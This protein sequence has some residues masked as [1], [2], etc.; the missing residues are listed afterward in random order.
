MFSP[1][2]RAQP[3][4]LRGIR[5]L[6]GFASCVLAQRRVPSPV[7]GRP[8][9]IAP[10]PRCRAADASPPPVSHPDTARARWKDTK[11]SP[12]LTAE[13]HHAGRACALLCPAP[14]AA[15]ASTEFCGRRRRDARENE[16]PRRGTRRRRHKSDFPREGVASLPSLS[17]EAEG[18]QRAAFEDPS[19]RLPFKSRWRRRRRAPGGR[20]L[21]H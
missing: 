7:P 11:R 16:V 1:P 14:V 13:G 15:M 21:V 18:S 2:P 9:L 10:E 4:D 17:L 8:H 6:R 5:R 3:R 19:A 20:H 12:R